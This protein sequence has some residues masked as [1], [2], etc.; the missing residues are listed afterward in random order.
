MSEKL[1][2]AYIWLDDVRP[3]GG[4]I[5]ALHDYDC[6]TVYS[7]NEA[8]DIITS[9]ESAHTRFIL[10]LDHDLGDYANDGGDGY[11]LTRNAKDYVI[12][13]IRIGDAILADVKA[14]TA[15]GQPLAWH[16]DGRVTIE[17]E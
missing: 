6:Y 2:I 7:V 13:D 10:D 4:G 11:K 9:C 8:K 17:E 3:F 14:M 16:T 1:F 15:K 12:T 5:Q